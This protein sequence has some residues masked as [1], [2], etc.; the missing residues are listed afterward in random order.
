MS[1]SA[2]PNLHT[3]QTLTSAK[4]ATALNKALVDRSNPLNILIQVNTSGEESKS[5]LPPLSSNSETAEDELVTLAKL[6]I[7]ECPKLHLQGLMTIGSLDQTLGAGEENRDFKT[8]TDT[9]DALQ[10]HLSSADLPPDKKWGEDGTGKLLL[11]MG[12]SSDFETALK[13]GSDIVRVGTGIFG[14]RRKKG[15]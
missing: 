8:L 2:I 12:M 1:G 3:I 6:I 14:E 11:S 9:R 4:A 7:T 5:G 13:A 15:E 10:R